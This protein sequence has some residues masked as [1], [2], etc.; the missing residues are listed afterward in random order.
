MCVCVFVLAKRV[1][2][3]SGSR[4][5]MEM[6]NIDFNWGKIQVCVCFHV[7]GIAIGLSG[8]V[9]NLKIVYLRVLLR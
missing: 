3:Q 9:N 6:E 8:Q 7:I 1:K 4:A 2:Q 5:E